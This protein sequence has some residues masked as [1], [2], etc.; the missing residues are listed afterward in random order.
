MFCYADY[1]DLEGGWEHITCS[2]APVYIL[3]YG[4]KTGLWI[5]LNTG[6]QTPGLL[7]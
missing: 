2:Y 6:E 7:Y 3:G 4:L 5:N 1:F